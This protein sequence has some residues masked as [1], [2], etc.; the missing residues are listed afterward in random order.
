MTG[1]TAIG[2]SVIEPDELN[3]CHVLVRGG[4][5]TLHLRPGDTCEILMDLVRRFDATVEPVYQGKLDDWSYAKR[6]VRESSDI[7]SEHSAGTAIDLNATQHPRGSRGTF[8]ASQRAAIR[9]LVDFYGG[10]IAWGGDFHTVPDEMHF[11][12]TAPPGSPLIKAAAHKVR[13]AMEDDMPTAD[14]IAE[15][16]WQ[17]LT[18]KA[19]TSVSEGGVQL[20]NRSIAAVSLVGARAG[21]AALDGLKRVSE[22][23]TAL[24]ASTGDDATK[25]EVEAIG[26]GLSGQID[27]V[28]AAIQPAAPPAT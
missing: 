13:T 28:L 17:K 3:T 5:V 2:W 18:H 23:L 7:W 19:F 21:L 11:E 4:T 15:A 8:S 22:Q 10:V 9:R 6:K 24:A 25:A 14:E 26:I 16:V 12:V 27:N 20:D 1:R